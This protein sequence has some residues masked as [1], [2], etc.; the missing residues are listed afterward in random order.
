M[1]EGIA[2]GDG[3]DRIENLGNITVASSAS[4]SLDAYSFDFG[5]SSSGEG[6]LTADSSAVGISGGSDADTIDN[7]RTAVRE[8]RGRNDRRGGLRRGLR[9]RL[10]RGEHHRCH[11]RRRNRRRRWRRCDHQPRTRSR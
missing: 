4:M 9:Q 10:G 2:G 6:T 1:A 5:G 3:A 7:A 8:R 11:G